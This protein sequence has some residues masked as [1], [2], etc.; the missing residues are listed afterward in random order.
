MGAARAWNGVEEE[1][2]LGTGKELGIPGRFQ[3][4]G[5]VIL[6]WEALVS[7]D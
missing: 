7:G 3:S 6:A 2:A 4:K 1:D 5:G